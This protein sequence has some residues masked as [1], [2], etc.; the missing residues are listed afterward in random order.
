MEEHYTQEQ[1]DLAEKWEKVIDTAKSGA[2]RAKADFK[3]NA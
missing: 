2:S 3:E 1:K